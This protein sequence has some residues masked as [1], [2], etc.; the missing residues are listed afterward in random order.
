M[1]ASLLPGLRDLR[2]PLA[3]GFLWAVVA[4][5]LLY[6]AIPSQDD[7]T[8]LAAEIYKVLGA[9]GS[10]ALITV[11][12]FVAYLL[13]IVLVRP[14]TTVI[15]AIL[16]GFGFRGLGLSASSVVE[17]E[18][19]AGR[20]AAA[21]KQAGV[22][23]A[24]AP[25]VSDREGIARLLSERMVDEVP[26]VA[27]RL[28][29]DN[30]DLFDRYDRADAEAAFRFAVVL[31]LNVICVASA[32][33]MELEWWGYLVAA[34]VGLLLSAVLL[35]EGA[36]KRMESNDAIYQAVFAG[37][38]S[39]PS[40]ETAEAMVAEERARHQKQRE[41]HERESAAQEAAESA[42]RRSKEEAQAS[43]EAE[44]RHVTIGLRGGAAQGSP[45]EQQLTTLFVD[46]ANDSDR[47]VVIGGFQVDPPLSAKRY[48][49]FPIRLPAHDARTESIEVELI[50][51][52]PGELSGGP[53]VRF[54]ANMAYRLGGDAWTRSSAE[55]SVPV[56]ATEPAD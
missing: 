29:A 51:I 33:R 42:A 34:G 2:V 13:G 14:G 46:L 50:D 15:N 45:G 3:T 48:P 10:A 28:L 5:L 16:R 23:L 44:A 25:D 56:V 8:G 24:D 49:S 4:W 26:L 37:K 36:R 52:E 35:L 31:P 19:L 32:W 38:A 41:E 21:M 53:L 1:L 6:P 47:A 54:T 22:Q 30:R 9:F 7:A 20:T 18:Q 11:V 39:F 12:T 40:V 17:A 55:G 27:T 43:A